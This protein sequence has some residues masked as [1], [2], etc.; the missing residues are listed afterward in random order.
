VTVLARSVA[1]L[2]LFAAQSVPKYDGW[3]TDLAGC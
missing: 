3:V 1:A 2:A